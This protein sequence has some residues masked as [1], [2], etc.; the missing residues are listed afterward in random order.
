MRIANVRGRL[1]LLTDRGGIDVETASQ[2]R[3]KADPQAVFADW[4]AFRAWAD[5]LRPD[6]AAPV[7]DA[8]LGCP[9]PRPTQVFGIGMNYREHAAEAGLPV[10]QSPATFTK[11]PSCITGPFADV[12]LPSAHVDWEVELVVVIG[13]RARRVAEGDAWKH[14][15]GLTVGQDL[16]E[17]VV[18]WAGGGQFSLGKSFP[19]F[20]PIGPCLVTPDE[21]ANPDDLELG[22]SIDGE[23]MQKGRTSDMVFS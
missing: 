12:E 7:A 15:A 22:C 2:G 19:G 14:V 4:T 5:S 10:P 20:G 21:L 8:D 11:F 3:F 23:T 6:G 13:A 1:T 17:R 16:S 18:Q 9:V